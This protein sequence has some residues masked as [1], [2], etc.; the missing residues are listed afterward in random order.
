MLNPLFFMSAIRIR[1]THIQDF[2]IERE[3]RED[4]ILK[5]CIHAYAEASTPS[6]NSNTKSSRLTFIGSGGAVRRK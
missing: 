2:M 5:C 6:T 1:N 3:Y 4:P